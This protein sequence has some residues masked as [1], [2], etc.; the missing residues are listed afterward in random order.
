MSTVNFRGFDDFAKRS[1]GLI[2]RGSEQMGTE[3]AELTL[4]FLARKAIALTPVGPS[5][6]A[7]KRVA[8][9]GPAYGHMR[10]RWF[11][12]VGS[13]G[14][15][16]GAKIP[17]RSNVELRPGQK[18]SLVNDAA[19]ARVID[20][21]RKQSKPYSIEEAESR[22]TRTPGRRRKGITITRGKEFDR[23]LGSNQAKNG[24][25]KPLIAWAGAKRESII[26][27]AIRRTE[28]RVK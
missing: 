23:Q 5:E 18:S 10:S 27:T 11:K 9:D 12:V 7:A 28:D 4:A 8:K 20:Q 22:K 6:E 1:P 25:T 14:G 17:A 16:S 26:K 15:Y 21:G 13:T 24:I 2:R 19:H 3:T